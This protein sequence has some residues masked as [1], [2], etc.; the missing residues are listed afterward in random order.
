MQKLWICTYIHSNIV[1]IP[2]RKKRLQKEKNAKLKNANEWSNNLL[3]AELKNANQ[4]IIFR[5]AELQI[6]IH[7]FFVKCENKICQ[8][9]SKNWENSNLTML[10][11]ACTNYIS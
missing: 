1:V 6:A 8:V 11:L 7:R 3:N 9:L 5:N 10:I 4:L 2:Y